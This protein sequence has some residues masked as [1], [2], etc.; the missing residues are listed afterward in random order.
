MAGSGHE[1]Q[2]RRSIARNNTTWAAYGLLTVYTFCLASFIGALLPHLRAELGLGN[3]A[4][5][6]MPARSRLT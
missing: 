6:S 4:G 3:A 1:H 2:Y 5:H